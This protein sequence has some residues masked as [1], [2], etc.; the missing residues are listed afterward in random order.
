[1]NSDKDSPTL[2]NNQNIEYENYFDLIKLEHRLKKNKTKLNYFKNQL[3]RIFFIIVFYYFSSKMSGYLAFLEAFPNKFKILNFQFFTGILVLIL[4]SNLWGSIVGSIGGLIGELIY[5]FISIHFII[6]PH[7]LIITLIGFMSGLIKYNKDTFIR[8]LYIMRFFY[9]IIITMFASLL[10]LLIFTF[11]YIKDFSFDINSPA[12]SIVLFNNIQFLI[13]FIISCM[14][15]SPLIILAIDRFLKFSS[16]QFGNIYLIP[17][18]HHTIYDSDHA[19]PIYIGGYN[20][21]VCTRCTGMI[22]GIII[23]LFIQSVLKLGF[24]IDM[25]PNLVFLLTLLSPIPGIIDWGVQKLGF[26]KS[27]DYK[28]ILTGILVGMAIHFLTLMDPKDIR[29]P[30]LLITYFSI[31]VFLIIFSSKFKK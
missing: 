20:F 15:L 19:I 5:Q 25:D 1:L 4:L 12:G 6:W 11:I 2:E 24:Y 17:F 8:K 23:G 26:I 16:N 14:F 9:I 22:I 29:A 7:L 18:T 31:F 10:L 21:F 27:N 28:R 13:S 30:I 3:I